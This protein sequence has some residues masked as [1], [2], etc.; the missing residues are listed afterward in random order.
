MSVGVVCGGSLGIVTP[1]GSLAV[2]V[3]VLSV[4][5]LPPVQSASTLQ[6]PRGSQ[7]PLV[8][9][10]VE[11]QT[12]GPVATVQGPSPL[13][14]PH[15]L[16]VSQTPL[17]Q[18]ILPTAAVHVAVIDGC[19]A[20]GRSAPRCRSTASARR[21]W[22]AADAPL[23]RRAVGVDLAAAGRLAD[24]ADAADP[25]AADHRAGVHGAG[26]VAGEVAALEVGVADAGAADHGAVA[27][28]ARPVAVLV[29]AIVVLR[30][31]SYST[32]AGADQGPGRHGVVHLPLRTEVTGERRDPCRW[33]SRRRSRGWAYSFFAASL[34]QLP[35]GQSE[36]SAQPMLVTI[37]LPRSGVSWF[38]W[39]SYEPAR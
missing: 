18:T 19:C 24:A 30:W 9:H 25:G 11:R 4:H 37:L 17:M 10:A 23:G 36:S 13:L 38:E 33:G 28:V 22:V 8:L 32:G 16:S 1:L 20:S 15:L 29:A 7:S 27:R 26:P 2:Q 35:A 12:V 34:H 5:Q 14:R 31:C 6:P 21:R 3:W 39:M